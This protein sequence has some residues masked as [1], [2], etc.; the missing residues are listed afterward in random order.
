MR[1]GCFSILKVNA[2]G[3]GA[4]APHVTKMLIPVENFFGDSSEF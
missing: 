2:F 1:V 3:V 4:I